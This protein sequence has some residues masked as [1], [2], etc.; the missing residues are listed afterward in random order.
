MNSLVSYNWLSEYLDLKGVTPEDFARRVS[1]SGP[2]VEKLIPQGTDLD[3]IVVGRIISVEPHPN[4]DKLRIAHVNVGKTIKIVCGGSNLE[5]DQWVTVALIGAKVKWHGEG[6]LIELK[7]IE[8][9]GVA[10]EG[11]IC[12]ASEIGLAE[13]F[14]HG[15]REIVDLGKEI[16]ELKVKP[17]TPLAEALGLLGDV[18]MDIEV[19]TNR[20]D[21]MGMIGFARECG[22]ILDRKVMDSR[23]RGNDGMKKGKGKSLAVK[24]DAT[25]A[26]PRYMAVQMD[27]VKVESSPWWMKRRLLSAGIRPINNLVDI[28]NY[29]MLETAQPTHVFDASAVKGTIHVRMGKEGETIELLDGRTVAV[30]PIMLLIADAEK[31]IALAGVMGGQQSGVSDS[32]TSIIIESAAFD[33]VIVRRSA[34]KANTQSDAQQRF[35]KGLSVYSPSE[36]FARVVALIEELAGGT[37]ASGIVDAFSKKPKPEVFKISIDQIESLIGIPTP[38]KEMVSILTRL[39]F[40][41]KITGKTL[42]ATV[43]WWRDHDIENGRDLVEEIARIKGYSNIPPIVPM[44]IS[45]RQMDPEIIWERRMRDVAKGA[46][47]TEC[48]TYSFVS[49]ELMTKSGYDPSTM[50]SITNPLSA[51]FEVM[52]TTLLP[53]LLRVASE[54]R[55]RRSELRLCEIQNVYYPR[56]GNLPDE[57]LEFGAVFVGMKEPWRVAKGFVEHLIVELGL[58]SVAWK[59]LSDDPFWHP[60][61]AMQAFAGEILVAT[62]GEIHPNIAKAHKLDEPV[63][64]VDMPFEDLLPLFGQGRVYQAISI[65]PPALRDVALLVESR[66]EFAELERKIQEVG[67]NVTSVEWFDTYAGK[68]IPEGKKSVAMHITFADPSRTLTSEEVDVSMTTILEALKSTFDAE[69]RG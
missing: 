49:K 62:V 41:V 6:D 33:P 44:G 47:L 5:K 9:R 25:K 53:S 31:P 3:Q 54:N 29:V 23:L 42:S 8:I 48:Y 61:R 4:A 36:A 2:G 37:V 50:L 59:R 51:E 35:E 46:G 7:P 10:S 19:T 27:G 20:V 57:Q 32:T 68:G 58:P 26:C 60:G 11:M 1:L 55:E 69:V 52:R 66:C 56:E 65:Y 17:G 24:I 16:P 12:A 15:E 30:D 28:S 21:A 39:G 40:T 63:A 34:R 45:G 67:S 22:A 38:T 18:V 13:A 64:M 43:P 14:P